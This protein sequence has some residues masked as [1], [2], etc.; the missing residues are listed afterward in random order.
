MA[1]WRQ[2]GSNAVIGLIFLSILGCG[3]GGGGGCNP[4][5]IK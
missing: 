1:N 5:R 2:A 3:G 4:S